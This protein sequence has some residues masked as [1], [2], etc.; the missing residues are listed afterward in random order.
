MLSFLV[1]TEALSGVSMIQKHG[2][3]VK[4]ESVYRLISVPVVFLKLIPILAAILSSLK[5]NSLSAVASVEVAGASQHWTWTEMWR[6]GKN[7]TIFAVHPLFHTRAHLDAAQVWLSDG[8]FWKVT[9][10]RCMSQTCLNAWE[11]PLITIRVSRQHH[12]LNMGKSKQSHHSLSQ[13]HLQ[14]I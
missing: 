10:N 6:R 3:E 13:S 1:F 8:G 9:V 2:L 7:C 11:E 12:R 4:W 14:V 5:A